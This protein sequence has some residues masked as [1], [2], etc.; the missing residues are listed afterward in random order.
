MLLGLCRD[1]CFGPRDD[2]GEEG[3]NHAQYGD[4]HTGLKG[5]LKGLGLP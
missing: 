4:R 5:S 3:E 1:R 2:D